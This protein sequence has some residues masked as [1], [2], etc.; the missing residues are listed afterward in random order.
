MTGPFVPAVTKQ[1]HQLSMKPQW[2]SANCMQES[3]PREGRG[4]HQ[5]CDQAATSTVDIYILSQE[6]RE[7]G[8]FKDPEN[9]FSVKFLHDHF[10]LW[11]SR[12]SFWLFLMRELYIFVL[13]RALLADVKQLGLINPPSTHEAH[14]LCFWVPEDDFFFF[15]TWW[16]LLI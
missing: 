14:Q 4:C 5:P 11:Q 7:P 8:Y 15:F 16:M 2:Q 9:F 12:K 10:I 13:F 6:L 3:G 1:V